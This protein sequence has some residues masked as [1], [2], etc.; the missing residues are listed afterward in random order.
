MERVGG[1]GS[2]K[3]GLS[4]RVC[5]AISLA[6]RSP[7]FLFEVG[8]GGSKR[9]QNDRKVRSFLQLSLCLCFIHSHL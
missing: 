6:V 7:A 8:V 5:P 2:G 4:V 3:G 9:A 1:R